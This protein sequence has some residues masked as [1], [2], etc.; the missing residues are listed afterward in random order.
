MVTEYPLPIKSFPN[1]AEMIPLP[2][3]D[4]TPPV[5]K[6]Y[7]VGEILTII[8]KFNCCQKYYFKPIISNLIKIL[9]KVFKDAGI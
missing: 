3:D 4:V 8:Y 9:L 5:T 7:F 2:S 6:M 1:D